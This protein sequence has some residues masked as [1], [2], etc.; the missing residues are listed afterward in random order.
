[1]TKADEFAIR[2][3]ELDALVEQCRG[4]IPFADG[5]VRDTSNRSTRD[6]PWWSVQIERS[7]EEWPNKTRASATVR[8]NCTPAGSPGSFE[9]EWMVRVWQG[10]SADSFRASGGWS[11]PWERPTPQNLEDTMIALLDAAS[12][13]IAEQKQQRRQCPPPGEH[14]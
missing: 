13:A 1:M 11:L 6:W 2:M 5:V 9:G 10:V 7:D 12:A 14:N 8:L 3:T 4:H